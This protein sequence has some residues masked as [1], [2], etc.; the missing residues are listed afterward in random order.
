V[1]EKHVKW[2]ENN[3]N[4]LKLFMLELIQNVQIKNSWLKKI[5]MVKWKYVVHG[6]KDVL[7]P[8]KKEKAAKN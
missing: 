4:L 7:N 2:L 8:L 6:W 1:K 3:V 5:I